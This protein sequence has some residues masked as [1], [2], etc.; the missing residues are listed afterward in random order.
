MF[1]LIKISKRYGSKHVLQSIDLCLDAEVV[2]LIGE[3]GAGKTTLLQI[4]LGQI[5]ADNGRVVSR[6]AA[7]GY[8]QQDPLSG[9]TLGDGFQP[10]LETWRKESALQRVG[11]NQALTFR[12][13][14]L[15]GGQKTRLALAYVL[16]QNPEPN[17]LLLDEPT[18]NLDS[19]AQQ[20]LEVFVKQ[21]RGSVIMA[22]HDRSFINRTC[23]KV[24]E[25]QNGKLRTYKGRYDDYKEQKDLELQT[26]MNVYEASI[27]E[28]RRLA[29]AILSTKH[30]I[31]QI[32]NKQ[33]KRLPKES[34]APIKGI[35][36]GAQNVAGRK[37]KALTSRLEQ[38][39]DISRPDIL[40]RH[41]VNLE[42]YVHSSKTILK[43]DNIA[44]RYH[45]L[46]FKQ[47]ELNITGGERVR[48]SGQNGS[49]KSTLLKIAVGVA[50]PT[51]GTVQCGHNVTIGYLSQGINSLDHQ[52]TA[53]ANLEEI[54][55]N[56][57]SIY[58]EAQALGFKSKDLKEKTNALSLGQQTKLSFCKLL[59]ANHD[60]LVLDEPTNHLG[61]P[62]REAIEQ[63]LQG[64]QGAMLIVSHDDYF[65]QAIGVTQEL[66]L[67]EEKYRLKS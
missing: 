31:S 67:D 36:S 14:D 26:E 55:P 60:L 28:R 65:V 49:G 19:K 42:G 27:K 13:D 53:L 48:I 18:N 52:K 51:A 3:N 23:T 44:M 7:Y 33:Y 61:I 38:M 40:R 37:T 24:L 1:K 50:S 4:I 20:W 11:L 12:T 45:K 47:L 5:Q 59:L 35:K 43:L 25:L 41:S 29:K 10:G 63:A 34:K 64:Y 6:N 15:S 66:D 58:R 54:T 39:E 9:G 2:A 22:S 57:T 30:R 56:K 21:F 16:A 17:V 46:L 62:A 32:D 8:M